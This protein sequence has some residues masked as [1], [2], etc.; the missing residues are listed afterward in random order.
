MTSL[1]P[2]QQAYPVHESITQS[3]TFDQIISYLAAS[4]SVL[5]QYDDSITT[6]RRQ[7][8]A[9]STKVKTNNSI[10][11]N[12]TTKN[13]VK[14]PLLTQEE[15]VKHRKGKQMT[16]YFQYKNLVTKLN[17]C[18]EKEIS[19]MYSQG[20]P[21]NT[22]NSHM[23][24][25]LVKYFPDS[26]TT[27]EKISETKN[28]GKNRG[29]RSPD[30]TGPPGILT[31]SAKEKGEYIIDS[32][33]DI[34]TRIGRTY[35]TSDCNVKDNKTSITR[36]NSLHELTAYAV[37]DTGCQYSSLGTIGWTIQS[38]SNNPDYHLRG[39]SAAMLQNMHD[40][41]VTYTKV[42]T[43][44]HGQ[45]ILKVCSALSFPL[46]H[47]HTERET[48]FSLA[49]IRSDGNTVDMVPQSEGGN[50]CILLKSTTINNLDQ[51]VLVPLVIHGPDTIVELH[52]PTENY[53][54]ILHIVDLTPDGWNP[55]DYDV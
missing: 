37:M 31:A 42:D 3:H 25:L 11:S 15:R 45:I 30:T 14:K 50:Q 33:N 35:S 54:D 34:Y 5:S 26:N 53:T 16:Y 7:R 21:W 39:A 18:E 55:T 8:N 4:D 2:Q 23:D 51:P 13:N 38:T 29:R 46:D 22:I 47:P 24:K 17:S 40:Q 1:P 41:T 10:S 49:H 19:K 27:S 32:S 44:Y 36:R 12:N 28:W 43:F 52:T 9:S 48:L 6:S 20:T